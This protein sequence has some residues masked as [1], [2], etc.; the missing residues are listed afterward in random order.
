LDVDCERALEALALAEPLTREQWE[1]ACKQLEPP[2]AVNRARAARKALLDS[3]RVA[4]VLEASKP[5][6]PK[7][8][9]QA[10]TDF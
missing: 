3:K 9:F 7:Q 10:I 5:G 2:L 6:A 4:I 1:R 8:R